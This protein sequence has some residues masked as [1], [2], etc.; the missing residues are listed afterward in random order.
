MV[1]DAVVFISEVVI[2]IRSQHNMATATK[3]VLSCCTVGCFSSKLQDEGVSPFLL[4]ASAKQN[5]H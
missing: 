2:Q 4:L 3:P 5:E 1:S